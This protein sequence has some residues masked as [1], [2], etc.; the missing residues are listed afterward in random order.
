[1]IGW[2]EH[3]RESSG[4]IKN[5]VFPDKFVLL[6]SSHEGLSMKLLCY[7]IICL[8]TLSNFLIRCLKTKKDRKEKS[9]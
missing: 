3:G 1:V 7:L 4:F 8:C 9:K 2:C 6:L 5:G